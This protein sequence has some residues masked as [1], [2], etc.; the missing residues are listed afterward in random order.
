MN[1]PCDHIQVL[2]AI[3]GLRKRPTLYIGAKE[4]P[5]LGARLACHVLEFMLLW[6][7]F[8]EIKQLDVTVDRE[9]RVTVRADGLGLPTERDRFR[10]G[11]HPIEVWFSE[12]SRSG[13]HDAW[14][15]VALSTRFALETVRG[16]RKWTLCFENGELTRRLADE[17]LAEGQG[18]KLEFQLDPAYVVH[19]PDVGTMFAHLGVR[20]PAGLGFNVGRV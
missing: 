6:V 5:E 9:H 12:P 18:T 3:E 14:M 13:S 8:G 2:T 7:G 17:G 20:A 16:G 10:D 19:P 1:Y 4:N 15:A 11:K